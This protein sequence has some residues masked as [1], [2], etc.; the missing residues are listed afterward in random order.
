MLLGVVLL[1]VWFNLSEWFD[2]CCCYYNLIL[3]RFGGFNYYWF[4]L[5]LFVVYLIFGIVVLFCVS[6][7]RYWYHCL[8]VIN[9]LFCWYWENESI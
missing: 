3:I 6:L 9:L 1:L 7:D 2:Y 4:L 5:W 8:L